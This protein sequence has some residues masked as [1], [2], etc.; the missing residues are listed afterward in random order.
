MNIISKVIQI[1]I[2]LFL[3]WI[4]VLH[5]TDENTSKRK[6]RWIVVLY[7]FGILFPLYKLIF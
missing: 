2:I 4:L 1:G 5:L 7:I 3:T 6:K